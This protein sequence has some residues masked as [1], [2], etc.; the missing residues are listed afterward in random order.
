M[1]ALKRVKVKVKVIS[2]YSQRLGNWKWRYSGGNYLVG[3]KKYQRS[4]GEFIKSKF[5]YENDNL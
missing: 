2:I 5:F 3:G 4:D 1:I